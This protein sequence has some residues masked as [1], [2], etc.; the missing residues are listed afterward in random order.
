MKSIENQAPGNS[1]KYYNFIWHRERSQVQEDM[2]DKLNLPARE[3]TIDPYLIEVAIWFAN[4]D[5][6]FGKWR[7]FDTADTA[8]DIQKFT[9]IPRA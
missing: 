4:I 8:L 5:P 7:V 2:W 3:T 1:I 9:H 6:L